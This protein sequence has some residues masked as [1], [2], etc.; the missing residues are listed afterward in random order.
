MRELLGK[1]E[2]FSIIIVVVTQIY[3]LSKLIETY[4][5]K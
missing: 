2:M 4:T 3:T 1:I 5:K